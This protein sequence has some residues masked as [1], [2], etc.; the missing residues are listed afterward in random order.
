MKKENFDN[1][2]QLLQQLYI[3]DQLSTRDIAKQLTVAQTT[4][5][6]W[7]KAFNIKTRTSKEGIE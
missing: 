1:L 7:L 2:E 3:V 6:R 5:R 4:V